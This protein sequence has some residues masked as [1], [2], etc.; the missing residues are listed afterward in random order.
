MYPNIKDA[1][2]PFR[3]TAA[4]AM[5]WVLF[6]TGGVVERPAGGGMLH[7]FTR[8]SGE[9]SKW[10]KCLV[11]NHHA[12]RRQLLI[13]D[14]TIHPCSVTCAPSPPSALLHACVCSSAPRPRSASRLASAAAWSLPQSCVRSR[15]HAYV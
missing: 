11:S 9:L 2:R 14:K 4:L 6:G 10:T 3:G 1:L 13:G 12:P 8:C 5:Q 15:M 7:H